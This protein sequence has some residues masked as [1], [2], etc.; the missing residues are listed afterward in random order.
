[1]PSLYLKGD[2]YYISVQ[3]NGIRKTRSLKTKDI[4]VAKQ[5]K[6]LLYYDLV[7]QIIN[8]DKLKKLITAKKLFNVYMAHDHNWSSETRRN[9]Q[10]IIGAYLDKRTL[11]KNKASADSYKRRINTM[12]N[13]GIKNKY[14]CSDLIKFK[15][16]SSP[17]SRNRIFNDDEIEIIISK[18]NPR[19]FRQFCEFAYNTGARSGE[20]RQLSK[21]NIHN[22]NIL[23]NGKTG[24]RTIKINKRAKELLGN[25]DYTRSY[26][27]H[28]FKSQARLFAIRNARFHDLRRTFGYKLIKK[29]MSIY[30][31]SK[32][33][34]HKS[35]ITTE[36]HYAPLLVNDIKDFTL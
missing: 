8:K 17:P 32:L 29:G 16:A 22:G 33:L 9:T 19:L 28:Q 21:D 25:Y 35:V 11:P 12:L 30:Q 27:S 15:L 3:Y 31:V 4:S 6:P 14:Q 10:Y 18:F 5:L 24:T 36:N 1:M 34:G 2:T 26:I 13:W 7:N 23:V 20:I